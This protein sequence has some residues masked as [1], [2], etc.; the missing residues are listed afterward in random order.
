MTILCAWIFFLLDPS[1]F[2]LWLFL[3]RFH[4]SE[5]WRGVETSGEK[6]EESSQKAGRRR[7]DGRGQ[8]WRADSG[9]GV[10]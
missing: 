1:D 6:T 7:G 9:W 4:I 10:W 5:D 3:A 8:Q 2:Y